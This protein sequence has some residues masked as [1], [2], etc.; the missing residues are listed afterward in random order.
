MSASLPQ[1]PA[2]RPAIVAA[3]ALGVIALV[4]SCSVAN[5]QPP[6][7]KSS[8]LR[9]VLPQEPPTLEPCESSLT[10]TGVVVRSNITEPLLERDPSTGE[11]SPLLATEWKRTSDTEWTFTLRQGVTFQDGA[12]LTAQDAAFS[13]DRAVNSKLGCNVDGYVFGDDPLTVKA[14]DDKTL[15]V[16]SKEP[17][18]ILPL[19][20]SFIEIVPKST[21]TTEKVRQP[22]GTGPYK[23][24]KW[25]AGLKLT[26]G[27][28]QKY[29]GKAPSFQT[30]EYQWRDEGTVR[31]AMVTSG[32]ADLALGIGP[33]DGAGDL[34]V[35]YP[36]NETTALR[37]TGEEAPLN[38]IRVRQ[39][40]NYALDK[41]SLTKS[42]LNGVGTPAGQLVPPGV[43]GHDKGIQPWPYDLAKA[44]SLVAEAKA[45][46][47]PVDKE[48]LLLA[49]NAQFPRVSETAEVLQEQL[50]QA[51]LKVK[52]RMVD[53]ST[54]LQYQLRPFV[55][56]A[57]PV[58]VLVMHGNQA[59]DA[60]FTVGQY[61]GT[62][63]AQ[64]VMGDKTL[65]KMIDEAN[66]K[67]G[68][69]R[70]DAFAEVLRY[71]NDKV[72]QFAHIAH[73]RGIIA[74]SRKVAYTPNAAT[75]DEMRLA[76]IKPAG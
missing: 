31:A 72:V 10:S 76:D 23:I 40:I 43:V 25:D 50:T 4:G 13:I 20:L 62:E 24:D 12:P 32:E 28:N 26:L 71:Q 52:L 49:R 60:A 54:H 66:G 1:P 11:L 74:L 59:G 9:V 5:T 75:S 14:V 21:S 2:V 47:V 53:T 58:A 22:V 6:A 3:A 36:N 42:L 17:D 39:A 56:D 34:G 63:G 18:P 45:D 51:G 64:S 7:A 48:I 67:Q 70:Q 37:L 55:K 46:G 27:R 69:E 30:V 41:D 65:D 35:T 44:K 68:Q 8:A 33:T 19:R 61:M 29:W 16:A 57:G 38:D 15:T 73:M